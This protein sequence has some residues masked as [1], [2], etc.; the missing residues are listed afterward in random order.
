MVYEC[1]WW[2]IMLYEGLWWLIMLLW[3]CLMF[4]DGVSC[5]YDG[6]WCFMMAYHALWWCMMLYA[7]LC[8][9]LYAGL[10]WCMMMYDCFSWFIMVYDD[11]WWF[12][13]VDDGLSW[14]LVVY[15]LSFDIM[16]F[17]AYQFYHNKPYS[18]FVIVCHG[19]CSLWCFILLRLYDGVSWF[20]LGN[21]RLVIFAW[22]L[23][24][25]VWKDSLKIIFF[26]QESV[27]IDS[28]DRCMMHV[29]VALRNHK[30]LWMSWVEA[31]GFP[32]LRFFKASI[33]NSEV[34]WN[35]WCSWKVLW[36]FLE[37]FPESYP[38]IYIYIHHI[39]PSGIHEWWIS[40]L[41]QW[42]YP[43][44]GFHGWQSIIMTSWG[45]AESWDIRMVAFPNHF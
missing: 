5:F 36:K 35:V 31:H 12:I 34:N 38:Y 14:I 9:M 37:S 41:F 10:W 23:H 6:A 44:H 22:G 8:M 39:C 24:D 16:E 25:H 17:M 20:I 15:G 19:L 4:D 40:C 43:C 28:I 2:L 32:T 21:G 33:I 42:K 26:G 3:W 18:W 29:Y 7:G 27:R 45:L 13:M 30:L 1:L 11:V